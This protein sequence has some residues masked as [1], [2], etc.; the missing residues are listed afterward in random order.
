VTSIRPATPDDARGITVIHVEAWQA[1]YRG[2]VPDDYLD[3]LSIDARE[4]VWRQILLTGDSSTWV[5][6]ESET[7]VGWISAA[8]SRDSDAGTST[9]E[10]WA[11]YVAPARWGTGVGRSLCE[12]AE[13]YL[14]QQGFSEVTLWVLRDNERAVRFYRSNGFVVDSGHT[15]TLERG[16]KTLFEARFRKPLIAKSN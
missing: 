10:V 12:T 6:M 15:K 3:S 8:G 9:G 5:A 7:I 16:G 2:I 14:R 13:S 1:A 11:I 4:T